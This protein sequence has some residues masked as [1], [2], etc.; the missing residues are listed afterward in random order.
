MINFRDSDKSLL[1]IDGNVKLPPNILKGLLLKN[2]ND[3]TSVYVGISP[4]RHA[5]PVNDARILKVWRNLSEFYDY[6]RELIKSCESGAIDYPIDGK[7]FSHFNPP[8]KAKVSKRHLR[9]PR[10]AFDFLQATDLF[11]IANGDT[12]DIMPEDTYF[13][14]ENKI[15]EDIIDPLIFLDQRMP[16]IAS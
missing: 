1:G 10:T 8:G 3:E 13:E 9:L 2:F 15:A 5:E 6:K 4:E 12:F 11:V 14:I 16:S 7:F